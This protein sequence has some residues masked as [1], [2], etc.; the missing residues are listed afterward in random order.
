M[1]KDCLHIIFLEPGLWNGG[2]T[3]AEAL[4]ALAK[5]KCGLRKVC[6]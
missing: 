2:L 3:V 5:G 4:A 6:V 1:G